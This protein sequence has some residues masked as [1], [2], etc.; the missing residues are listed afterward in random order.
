MV[1][2]MKKAVKNLS[3]KKNIYLVIG[4]SVV[5]LILII[6]MVLLIL[7]LNSHNNKSNNTTLAPISSPI[8][9]V[10][11]TPT[12][13]PS[14]S[15]VPTPSPSLSPTPSPSPTPSSSPKP[16]PSVS[17]TE[18]TR[19]FEE[20]KAVVAG[21]SM[22]EGLVAYGVLPESNVVWY[23]G[24]RIDNMKTD[25]PK[26]ISLQPKYLFLTYGS[27]DLELWIGKVD[28]F[29]NHFKNILSYIRSVL[30]NTQIIINSILPVSE[31]AIERNN[32]FS[33]QELFNTRLKELADSEGIPFLEN[34]VYLEYN[35]NPFST[36][37]VHPK[38]FYYP[39][40]AK[41]MANYLEN[42]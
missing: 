41:N 32:A 13:S 17:K 39:L 8:P 2:Y 33:Y 35:A 1:R 4:I 40:W 23:R 5:C 34:S 38:G 11:P 37:G 19:I 12:Q 22:A 10:T 27:N 9:S 20:K 16:V 7:P 24:R 15:V 21:D 26:I 3:D 14:P 31:A 28:P 36:D 42:H 18:I 30:P 25:M 29:I 6:I